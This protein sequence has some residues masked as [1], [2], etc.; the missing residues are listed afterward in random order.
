MS[1]NEHGVYPKAWQGFT[2]GPL[3]DMPGALAYWRKI[4]WAI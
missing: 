1:C 3:W 4:H 2:N